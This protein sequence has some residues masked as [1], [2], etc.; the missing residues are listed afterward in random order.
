MCDYKGDGEFE[1]NL[2][3]Q[4]YQVQVNKKFLKDKVLYDES[5]YWKA[6]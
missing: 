3:G 1:S 2:S 6:L 5:K 4:K